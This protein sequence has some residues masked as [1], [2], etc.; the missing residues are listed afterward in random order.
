LPSADSFCNTGFCFTLAKE[1][2]NES[3]IPFYYF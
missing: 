1:Q 2:F 3:F